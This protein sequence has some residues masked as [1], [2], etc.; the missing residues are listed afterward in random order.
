MKIAKTIMVQGTASGVGKSLITTA[1]CRIFKQDGFSPAPFKAINISLNSGVTADGKEI[2]TSQIVQAQ[3]CEISAS[4]L[5]NPFLIKP[6]MGRSPQ[7]IIKGKVASRPQITKKYQSSSGLWSVVKNSFDALS[8]EHGL[9]VLE[10]AASPAEPSFIQDDVVNLKI[11]K[12]ANSPVILVGDIDKGGAFASLEGTIS[13]LKRFDPEASRL[14]KGIVI[15]KYRGQKRAL[16]LACRDLTK[17]TGVPVLGIIP[18]IQDHG[19]ADEDTW[20]LENTAVKLKNALLDV[21]II[22]LPSLQNSHDFDP[23]IRE[24]NLS[25]RFVSNAKSFGSPD[26]IV[27]PGSKNTTYDLQW[28]KSRN[29]ANK[30]LNH[31]EQEGAVIGICGGLQILGKRIEDPFAV[32]SGQAQVKGLGLLELTTTFQRAKTTK[33]VVVKVVQNSGLLQGAKGIELSG[34]EIHMGQ[35]TQD[36]KKKISGFVSSSSGWVIGTYLHDVFA[37]TQLCQLIFQNIARKKGIFFPSRKTVSPVSNKYDA[38]AKIVRQ[39]MDLKLLYR[40]LNEKAYG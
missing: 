17:V 34:Y 6:Q 25:V 2:A 12:Y 37:N 29:L 32:E 35:S 27:L 40:I 13:I 24:P 30:I 18:F 19:V 31:V 1:L 16:A 28:L 5:M 23:L 15:N 39:N 7:V 21:A 4:P 9:I 26:L 10:G 36:N 11:A 22:K 20:F 8:K 38:L 3:A 14:I 33:Q